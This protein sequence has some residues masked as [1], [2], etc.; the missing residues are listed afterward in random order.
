MSY[1]NAPLTISLSLR[2]P[3]MT[4]LH[5]AGLAGLY[6]TLKKLETLF[7]SKKDRPGYLDWEL[8]PYEIN[9]KWIG[10]DFLVIEWL[11]HQ[12]FQIDSDGLISFLGWNERNSFLK[13]LHQHQVIKETFL[14]HNRFFRLG[15]QKNKEI[16]INDQKIKVKYKP[17]QWY[18]HQSFANNLCSN[19]SQNLL[20]EKIPIVSCL[21]LG[22]IVR[23]AK[24]DKFTKLE[25]PTELAFT[26]LFAPVV[27]EYFLLYNQYNKSFKGK[28]KQPTKSLLVLP[29]ITNLEVAANRRWKLQELEFKSLHVSNAIEPALTYYRNKVI[30]EN[31]S[32]EKCQVLL[33]ENF[34]SSQQK[35]LV[36]IQELVI[37]YQA[38]LDYELTNKLLQ[39]NQILTFPESNQYKIRVNFIRGIFAKNLAIENKIWIDFFHQCH[40]IDPLNGLF[41]QL[42]FNAKGVLEMFRQ[43]NENDLQIYLEYIELFHEGLKNTYAIIYQKYDSKEAPE[44]IKKAR[45]RIRAEL[46]R[47]Y[48]NKSFQF[49][50]AIFLE[51]ANLNRAN[52]QLSQNWNSFF[53]LIKETSW[54]EL[55]DWSILALASYVPQPKE[56]VSNEIVN[57]EEV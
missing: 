43:N 47:C 11:L 29:F 42:L 23:H 15:K 19:Q 40:E 1:N 34:I 48:D 54:E 51:R 32:Q 35:S 8:T 38:L 10:N 12:S 25:E 57:T 53:R 3:Q 14:R 30:R 21:Y 46:Y 24:L 6:M 17:L 22:G 44:R 50:I 13:K 7:P 39:D 5:R 26:L 31:Q 55:R 2:N 20:Q 16:L 4:V 37:N 27:I 28:S 49:F 41:G 52:Q 36:D 9:L 33:Y 56:E 45:E 18:F